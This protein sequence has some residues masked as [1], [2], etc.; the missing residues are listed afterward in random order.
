MN[1]RHLAH[2]IAATIALPVAGYA[3]VSGATA[4]HAQAPFDSLYAHR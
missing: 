2:A 3:Q 4:T 1:T